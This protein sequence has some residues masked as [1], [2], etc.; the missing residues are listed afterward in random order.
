MPKMHLRQPGFRYLQDITYLLLDNYKKQ[1][2]NSIVERKRELPI[3]LPNKLDKVWFQNNVLPR[4][5]LHT[6]Y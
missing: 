3:Y 4:K 2:K 1:R 5:V 6:K